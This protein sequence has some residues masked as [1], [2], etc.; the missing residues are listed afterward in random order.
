MGSNTSAIEG[1]CFCG[2][3]EIELLAQNLEKEGFD[4]LAEHLRE[5]STD[6]ASLADIDD[7]L[8]EKH[9]ANAS[10]ATKNT[11]REL[12]RSKRHGTSNNIVVTR[13]PGEKDID[14]VAHHGAWSHTLPHGPTLENGVDLRA[15]GLYAKPWLELPAVRCQLLLDQTLQ[16]PA[17]DVWAALYSDEAN[18]NYACYHRDVLGHSGVQITP[19]ALHPVLGQLRRVSYSIGKIEGLMGVGMEDYE[20]CAMQNDGGF[21]LRAIQKAVSGSNFTD[22]FFVEVRPRG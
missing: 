13:L 10:E 14:D 19:W 3:E 6:G 4:R 18:D 5:D 11:V 16:R 1:S 15:A 12:V 7:A 22:N 21:E 2:S 9:L 20:A 17:T 8:L